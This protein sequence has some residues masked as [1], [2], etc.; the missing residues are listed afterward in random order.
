MKKILLFAF[1]LLLSVSL[2]G[3]ESAGNMPQQNETDKA[4]ETDKEAVV[5]VVEGFGK[6]LQTVSLLAPKDILGKY[7]IK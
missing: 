6:K 5:K 1:I 4:G 7:D 2:L 3:C